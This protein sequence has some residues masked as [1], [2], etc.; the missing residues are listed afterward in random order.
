MLRLACL[1]YIHLDFASHTFASHTKCETFDM[2]TISFLFDDINCTS[3][4]TELNTTLVCSLWKHHMNE[5]GLNYVICTQ[6]RVTQNEHLWNCNPTVIDIPNVKEH[7]YIKYRIQN[8]AGNRSLDASVS[9]PSILIRSSIELFTITAI[10]LIGLI[11]YI[12]IIYSCIIITCF[13]PI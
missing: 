7:I 8:L 2:K 13:S 1:L 3:S 11:F 12:G 9:V 4:K 10:S 5:I 6:P